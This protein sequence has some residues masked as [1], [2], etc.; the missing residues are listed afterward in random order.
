MNFNSRNFNLLGHKQIVHLSR[1]N[2][3]EGVSPLTSSLEENINLYSLCKDKLPCTSGSQTKLLGLE[4]WSDISMGYSLFT[5]M[6]KTLNSAKM[7]DLLRL[8]STLSFPP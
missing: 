7:K 5:V 3:T 6:P 2:C 1:S 4:V 8:S